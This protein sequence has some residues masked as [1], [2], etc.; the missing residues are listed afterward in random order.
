MIETYKVE[1]KEVFPFFER[2]GVCSA[3]A[4]VLVDMENKRARAFRINDS[5]FE[6]TDECKCCGLSSLK[7]PAYIMAS[8][9]DHFVARSFPFEDG[10]LMPFGD[11][12]IFRKEPDGSIT[13]DPPAPT[14]GAPNGR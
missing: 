13:I 9:V 4:F 7:V 11:S 10:G 8:A 1:G 3:H 14:E 5:F 6:K 2:T 12:L